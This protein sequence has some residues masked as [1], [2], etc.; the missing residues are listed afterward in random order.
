MSPTKVA[1]SLT[2][3]SRAS[4]TRVSRSSPLPPITTAHA[5]RGSSG[6]RP[7]DQVDSFQSGEPGNHEHVVAVA[8][9][10]IQPLGRR[11]VEHRRFQLRP[12]RQPPLN[13]TRLHE[14]TTDV[15]CEQV[16]IDGVNRPPAHAFLEASSGAQRR[17]E[18]IPEIVV[19]AHRVIE[20]ADVMGMTDRVARIPQ[21]DHAIDAISAA[22]A[23]VGQPRRDV[24]GGLAP[25][26]VLRRRDDVGVV[27][28]LAQGL[29]ERARDR[30]CPPSTIGGLD[31]TTAIRLI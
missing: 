15:A 30:Q 24:G 27:P 22:H 26:P 1:R 7:Q 21:T 25:E 6:E 31:V 8:V 28:S 3:S 19:L 12:H 2:P 4:A 9:A 13:R 17:R 14:E 20:P 5:G 11:R 23:H 10:A 29:H 16:P 18:A